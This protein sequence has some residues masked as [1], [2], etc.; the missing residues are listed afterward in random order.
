MIRPLG[1]LVGGRGGG[2]EAS[3]SGTWQHWLGGKLG[4]AV[5]SG[6]ISEQD[7]QDFAVDQRAGAGGANRFCFCSWTKGV[8]LYRAGEDSGEER[9]S[10]FDVLVL[11]RNDLVRFQ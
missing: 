10:G 7:H 6:H 1:W 3:N 8:A 9:G 2:R 5:G 4:E 11:V